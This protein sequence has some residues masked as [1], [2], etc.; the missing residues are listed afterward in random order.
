MPKSRP[1]IRAQVGRS[2]EFAEGGGVKKA[3]NFAVV[4]NGGP[5]RS[6]VQMKPWE[7]AVI[8]RR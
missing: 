6:H 4:L 1:S 3:E 8:V 5:Q 2:S 7:G